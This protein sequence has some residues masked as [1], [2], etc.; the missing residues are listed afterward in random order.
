MDAFAPDLTIA[1]IPV[2]LAKNPEGCLLSSNLED[3]I[4]SI[5]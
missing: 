1:V 2:S 3:R 4:V 5:K